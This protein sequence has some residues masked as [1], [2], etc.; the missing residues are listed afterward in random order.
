V[1]SQ[2]WAGI[3]ARMAAWWPATEY[4]NATIVIWFEELASYEAAQVA[5]AI[6]SILVN[7]PG[8]F[9]P[10]LADLL[11]E[12][13]PHVTVADIQAA[14]RPRGIDAGEPPRLDP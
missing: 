5:K 2:E 13:H 10:S 3:A 11:A 4:T 8:A 1:T 14:Q 7:R 12:L 6:R 9:G